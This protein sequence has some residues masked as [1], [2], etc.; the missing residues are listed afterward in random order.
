MTEQQ[1]RD[2]IDRLKEAL[3]RAE[4]ARCATA[5]KLERQDLHIK[6]IRRDLQDIAAQYTAITKGEKVI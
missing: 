2:R 6:Q 5:D 4:Y 1:M 3:L